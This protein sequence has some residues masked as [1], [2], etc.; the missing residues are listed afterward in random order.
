MAPRLFV[1]AS[2]N[3][4]SLYLHEIINNSHTQT[5][6][7]VIKEKEAINLRAG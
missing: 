7:I 1:K 3:Q 5:H 2:K 6:I 4:I